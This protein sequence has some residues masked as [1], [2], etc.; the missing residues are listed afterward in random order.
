MWRESGKIRPWKLFIYQVNQI[1]LMVAF[2]FTA[3]KV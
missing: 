2:C 1:D 3:V